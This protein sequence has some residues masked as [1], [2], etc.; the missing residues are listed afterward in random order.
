MS[1]K[2]KTSRD[3]LLPDYADIYSVSMAYFSENDLAQQYANLLRVTK[4]SEKLSLSGEI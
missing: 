1:N 4:M 2:K 3:F